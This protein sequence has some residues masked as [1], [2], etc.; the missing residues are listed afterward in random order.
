M[1]SPLN[2]TL[3]V[4]GHRSPASVPVLATPPCPLVCPEVAVRTQAAGCA[5]VR[6][7]LFLVSLLGNLS[8]WAALREADPL[9]LGVPMSSQMGV[10]QPRFH[11]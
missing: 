3:T 8:R 5:H 2:G 11:L 9:S 6:R 10:H 4:C 7:A 1:L